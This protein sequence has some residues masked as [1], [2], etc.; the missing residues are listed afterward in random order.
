LFEKFVPQMWWANERTLLGWISMALLLAVGSVR[1]LAIQ[2]RP[3]QFAGVVMTVIAMSVCIYAF[4]RFAL[5][6][7]AMLK[8][9]DVDSPGMKDWFGPWILVGIVLVFVIAIVVV[10]SIF[11]SCTSC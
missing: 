8:G 11:L 7:H 4:C 3:S 2:A 6:Y 5:R 1:L 9:G 10:N